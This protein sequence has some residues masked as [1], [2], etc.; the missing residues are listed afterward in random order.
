MRC[1]SYRGKES[2]TTQLI[3]RR[4]EYLR[5]GRNVLF[6]ASRWF[7]WTRAKRRVEVLTRDKGRE[8]PPKPVGPGPQRGPKRGVAPALLSVLPASNCGVFSSCISLVCR[9]VASG[10]F[11][12]PSREPCREPTYERFSTELRFLPRSHLAASSIRTRKTERKT[13]RKTACRTVF[14]RKQRAIS[15]TVVR[16]NQDGLDCLDFP[17]AV[18][19]DLCLGLDYFGAV[20]ALACLGLRPVHDFGHLT[21][22]YGKAKRSD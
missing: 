9:G 18:F 15:S 17:P 8:R 11:I 12:E 7:R 22:D 4:K 5:G 16:R 10:R 13:A 1:T 3:R 14:P 20:R 21:S 19:A 6:G 2:A